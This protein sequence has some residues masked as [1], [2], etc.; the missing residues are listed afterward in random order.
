MQISLIAANEVGTGT[1]TVPLI[2]DKD[3]V[4]EFDSDPTSVIELVHYARAEYMVP[5]DRKGVVNHIAFRTIK[6]MDTVSQA[7]YTCLNIATLLPRV[8][9]VTFTTSGPQLIRCS[10]DVAAIARRHCRY[11]GRA[12]LY[13]F[14]FLGGEMKKSISNA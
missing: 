1:F 3:A 2:T 9:A 11:K 4:S 8:C 14:N 5:I 10:M 6:Y 13:D 12:V 7:E